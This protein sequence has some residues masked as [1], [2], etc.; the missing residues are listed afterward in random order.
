MTMVSAHFKPWIPDRPVSKGATAYH[1]A[2][3]KSSWLKEAIYELVKIV[4]SKICKGDIVV[5]Y[6]AGTGASAIFL[7]KYLRQR[8][9]LWLVD[10]SSSWLGKAYELL[11]DPPN[12][13]CFILEKKGDRYATLSE[14]I[15]NEVVDHVVSANTV[16]LIPNLKEAFSGIALALKKGGTFTFQ[17]A[18]LFRND[19]PEGILMIDETVKSVHDIAIDIVSRHQKFVI[20]RQG[21]NERVE[22][23]ESQR[24]FIFP[25]P[26]PIESYLY[27]LKKAGLEH[28]TPLYIPVK[29]KYSEWLNFLR[30][31]RLQAGILPE[32]GGK[33]PSPI[34]EKDRDTLITMA[35]LELFKDLETNNPLADDKSFTVES[36]YVLSEKCT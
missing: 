28:Q 30:V 13:E 4:N 23:E 27:A 14:T 29:I 22:S 9:R 3:V 8:M 15:G 5:D 6:G 25:D 34:E 20:Y 11:N 32:I 19:R 24:K 12:V 7:L 21:L 26:R 1:D 10:N 31:K 17:T 33:E 18:N 36:V 16:H 35:A 2:V